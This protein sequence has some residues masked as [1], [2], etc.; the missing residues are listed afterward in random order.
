MGLST[1]IYVSQLFIIC[2][3]SDGGAYGTNIKT[4]M[5][6]TIMRIFFS[7]IYCDDSVVLQHTYQCRCYVLVD[8]NVRSRDK[9]IW[10]M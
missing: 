3:Y 9:N 1:Y 6:N 2:M 5:I 10:G 7:V 4:N 8:R